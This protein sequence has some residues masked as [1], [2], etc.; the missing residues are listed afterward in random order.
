MFCFNLKRCWY[1]AILTGEKRTE[2][3][4]VKPYWE[5]R[6]TKL[7]EG[8]PVVF[9]CGYGH[10]KPKIHAHVISID[11]GPCPYPG[12]HGEYFRIHFSCRQDYP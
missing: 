9:S 5:K 2:Y 8:T 4:E 6:L 10:S 12:W 7:H 1:E 3:R 11:K